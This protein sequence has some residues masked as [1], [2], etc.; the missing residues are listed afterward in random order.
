MK[1]TEQERDILEKHFE[2][3][4]LPLTTFQR[5]QKIKSGHSFEAVTRELRRMR[6][7][8]ALQPRERAVRELRV[9]YLDIEASDLQADFGYMLSWYIKRRG[10]N[11]YDYSIITKDE[12]FRYEFDKR[13]TKELLEALN[14]YDVIYTHYGADR[15]FDLPF[16]RSRAY[17]WGLE[18]MLPDKGEKFLMDTWPIARNKL[19]LH[20]NR[21]DSIAEA[22]GI[23]G[24]KKTPLSGQTWV[25]AS[26]G[27]PESLEYIAKHNKHDVIILERIHK[28]LEKVE[29]K[30]Y[31]SL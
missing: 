21:L 28:K 20:S 16:I 11:E 9:G 2:G 23:K 6:Q 3:N 18:D 13:L 25:L 12:I 24:I 19:K 31:R 4:T 5:L 14:N 29:T 17:K 10:K 8:K 15:R 7:R 26:A 27:H 1:W 30:V 22:V